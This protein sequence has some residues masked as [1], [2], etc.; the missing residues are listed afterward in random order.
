MEYFIFYITTTNCNLISESFFAKILHIYHHLV[1]SFA[2]YLLVQ[3]IKEF[4]HLYFFK[5]INIIN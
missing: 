5:K 4:F 1:S 3:R 2:Y